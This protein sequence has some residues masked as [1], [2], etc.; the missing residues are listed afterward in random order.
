MT[1]RHAVAGELRK[2]LTLPSALLALVLGA[3]TT[4]GFAAMAANRMRVR[5]DSGDPNA[6]AYNTTMDIGFNLIPIGTVAAVVLGVVII[7]S[8][9]AP[10]SKDAGGGRQ[11]LVSL[12]CSPR[13]AVLLAAKA[14]VLML[15]TGVFALI[16]I[17]A[18]IALSQAVLG[19]HGNSPGAVAAALGWRAAGGVAYWVLSALIAFAVTV[20]T[21]SGI[22]PLVFFVANT[23][24]VSVTFLLTK[25]TPLANYLPDVAGAQMI[26]V[27]RLP[28]EGMLDPLPG[29]LVMA[30]WAA[31]LLAIAA[32]VFARRDA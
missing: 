25:L 31:A 15:V 30:A 7:S 19:A 5:L 8:E 4:L 1:L 14:I 16:T 21:R 18:V 20:L 9:Y 13:R 26:G 6:L 27:V 11:I 3:A 32:R 22:L 17:P 10:S 23:T 28:A 29:G 24:L 12:T 2:L